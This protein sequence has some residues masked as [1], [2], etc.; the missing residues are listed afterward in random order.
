[1][2]VLRTYKRLQLLDGYGC[3]NSIPVPPPPTHNGTTVH[4]WAVLRLTWRIMC[5][6]KGLTKTEYTD[7]QLCNTSLKQTL[8]QTS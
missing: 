2:L 3:F 6:C 8:Q 4:L 7:H 1:M 5:S